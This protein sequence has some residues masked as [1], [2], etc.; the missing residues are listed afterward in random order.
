M[1]AAKGVPDGAKGVACDDIALLGD[2]EVSRLL[3][4]EDEAVREAMA[5]PDHGD[6]HDEL[7]RPGVTL[8]LLWEEYADRCVSGGKAGMSY[9]TLA[10]GYPD[11]AVTR[12]V[13]NHLT[14]K[15][16]QATGVGWSGPAMRPAPS[17]EGSQG[18]TRLSRC[19][20]ARGMPMRGDLGHGA[21]HLVGVFCQVKLSKNRIKI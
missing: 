20:P 17:R 19:P 16:G 11:H 12:N 5:K 3:F 8:K 2:E 13:T 6:V 14:H 21:T 18:P 9:V 4:P 7:K 15:P 10:R 1:H